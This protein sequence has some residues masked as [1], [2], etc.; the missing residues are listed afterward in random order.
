MQLKPPVREIR[1]LKQVSQR[2]RAIPVEENDSKPETEKQSFIFAIGD[3]DEFIWLKVGGVMMQALI[4]SGCNKN[5][6]D[7]GTW[8][9]MKS[10]GVAIRNATTEVDHK[11]RGY[12]KDC[13]PMDVVGMFDATVEIV[14]DDQQANEEARFYVIKDGNQPLLGKETARQLNVLRLG[15]PEP[16]DGVYQ[17]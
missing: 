3:G 6:I 4:D 9:R 11:F 7:D 12:G 8:D 16:D 15:L 1:S 5:I 2:I 13:K 10:Q 14:S 17:V